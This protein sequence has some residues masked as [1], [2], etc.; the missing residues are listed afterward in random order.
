M[1]Y[2]NERAKAVYEAY[3][4]VFCIKYFNNAHY[5]IV[6]VS[7][8]SMPS[9]LNMSFRLIIFSLCLQ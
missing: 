9:T 8:H 5:Y 4:Q 6:S 1:A 2:R 7:W 3:G